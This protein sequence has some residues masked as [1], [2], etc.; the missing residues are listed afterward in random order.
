MLSPAMD[1]GWEGEAVGVTGI[2]GVRSCPARK[3]A[4]GMQTAGREVVVAVVFM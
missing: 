4:C 2:V 3:Q 1:S